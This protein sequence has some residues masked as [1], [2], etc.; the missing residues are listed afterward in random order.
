[1]SIETRI[2]AINDHLID[3]YAV[4]RLAGADLTNVDK[5]IVNLKPT[6]KERL[7]YFIN[8]GTDVVWDNWEKVTGEGT[9]LTLNNTL[10][11]KMKI[12]LK[13]NTYQNGEP[14]P[15][16]PI[17][18]QVVSGD[19]EVEVKGKNLFSV[20]DWLDTLG[21]TYTENSDG[22]I[23]LQVQQNLY[24]TTYPIK[25]TD[26]CLWSF[27]A[28][29]GTGGNF[30]FRYVYED[31]YI[32]ET[33]GSG[34][35]TSEVS[36]STSSSTG[37]GNVVGIKA[38]W[39]TA[40]T[41][42]I[43]ESMLEQYVY[44]VSPRPYEPYQ[45]QS[46]SVNLGV[47]N[48]FD[49]T[50]ISSVN[51]GTNDNGV[52]TSTTNQSAGLKNLVIYYANGSITIPA[53][54]TIY[55]SADIKLNS[56]STGEFGTINDNANGTTKVVYP[57]MSTTYQRYQ[58]TRTY[59]SATTINAML[60]QIQNLVGSVEVSN[61][62]ISIGK[63]ISFTPYG[64]TPIELCKIGD[65]QD[66]FIRNSGKNLYDRAN[67][68]ENRAL[69]WGTG[70]EFGETG[71]ITSDFIRT[72]KGDK[73]TITFSS[74]IMFYD[75]NK[76][77][78]G[79]LQ[80]GGETIAKTTGNTWKYFTTPNVDEIYYVKIGTRANAD[81][82]VDKLN[83]NIMLNKGYEVI[84]YEPYGTGWYLKKEIGKVVLDGSE[85][86]RNKE[87]D[88][89]GLTQWRCSYTNSTLFNNNYVIC[90]TLQAYLPSISF[91]TATY[92]NAI[93]V[94][95]TDQLQ[96]KIDYTLFGGTSSDS[97]S[98]LSEKFKIW[99][100]S[101]NMILYYSLITPTYEPITDTTLL[102]QLEALKKGKSYKGQ[103]NISQ[104]NNDLA[105]VLDVTALREMDDE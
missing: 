22:S 11:A 27:K 74:Q 101:N 14:T 28:K 8:N 19:N 62:M 63:S 59:T 61:I 103:T 77:Y 43:R 90:D 104:E 30:R 36:I 31:G 97:G 79:C 72:T 44:G 39:T 24:N 73:F 70:E 96:V 81:G 33:A 42:T 56:N 80:S 13:G 82:G 15:D 20:K 71:S 55:F 75:S 100:A 12:E 85:D 38:N 37:H 94:F 58:T 21:A 29:N 98:T 54:T 52:I 4:L 40:G 89:D 60:I 66:K 45:S 16:T 86:W 84:P 34:T 99:L 23:T 5:N 102:G 35:G 83:A 68:I 10:E 25:P 32:N 105:F 1:M 76:E 88:V 9:S 6:W 51:N 48:L 49:Y 91:Y 92:S 57:T 7:L 46:Y 3:D 2:E 78:L 47:E 41:F 87:K 95:L 93:N 18:V 64:T 50:K 26:R 53:N 65:Y 67:A 17:P 69:N